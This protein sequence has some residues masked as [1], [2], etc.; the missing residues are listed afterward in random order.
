MKRKKRD[1]RCGD[2]FVDLYSCSLSYGRKKRKRIRYLDWATELYGYLDEEIEDKVFQNTSRSRESLERER[3]INREV[4][5]AL[6]RLS[7]EEK[8]FI[9]LF[10]FEFRSY[11][12]IAGIL[13][14]KVYKLE[15]IHRRSLDKL[16]ILL[17]GFVKKQFKI[18]V[19][20]ETDCIICKS[21]FKREL[22]KLIRNKKEEETYS[23]LMRVFKQKYGIDVKTPQVIIGHRRK[24]MV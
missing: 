8:R 24:H 10:Y 4:R 1:R 2:H 18:K 13:K 23:R 6:E 3:S 16:K 20:E 15:R 21:P 5:K 19:P 17:A 9:Q 7:F 14:R 12:Q 11:Q 22:E